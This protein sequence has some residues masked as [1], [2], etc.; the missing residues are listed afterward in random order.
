MSSVRSK[1]TAPELR[2]RRAL[3]QR[4][5]RYRIHVRDLPGR[6]DLVF[7]RRR[8]VVFVDG[9]FWHGRVLREQGIDALASKFKVRAE[10]WT[11]KITKNVE[12]DEAAASVLK[13]EGWTVLRVWET[14]LRRDLAGAVERIIKALDQ[15]LS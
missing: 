7:F 13:E 9:D 4:G 3:W 8:T 12:R 1:D 2:L 14:D 15:A 10:W 6:P 5:F 11:R